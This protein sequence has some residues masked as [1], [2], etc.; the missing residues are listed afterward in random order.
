MSVGDVAD[1]ATIS[2]LAHYVETEH[3]KL[4]T[5]L[6]DRHRQLVIIGQPGHP[7]PPATFREAFGSSS[8]EIETETADDKG[9]WLAV[10]E[11]P[12]KR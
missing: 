10:V 2:E 5:L 12:A 6:N 11:D 8:F 4:R 9:R 3:P 7:E 1:L